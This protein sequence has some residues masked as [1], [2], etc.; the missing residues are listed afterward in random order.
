MSKFAY[1]GR[2]GQGGAVEGVQEGESPAAV[3]RLLSARGV[4]PI[5][6]RPVAEEKRAEGSLGSI[7]LGRGKPSADD[8]MFFCRQMHTLTRSGV[9][10]I[11]GVAGLAESTRNERLAEGLRQV[12]RDL[13]GGYSL[14]HA[15]NQ[16]PDLFSPLIVGILQVGENTGRVDES[17]RQLAFYLERE[18]DTRNRM[19]TA[20]RYPVMV[21]VAIGVAMA[22]INLFV[23]P[24]FAKVF[25]GFNAELPWATR[26]LLTSSRFTVEYWPFVFGGIALVIWG[27]L[28]YIRTETGR[29]WW[30]RHKLRLP[31]VGPI[32]LKSTLGRFARSFAMMLKAGVP[33]VQGLS[34]LTAAV[35]NAYVGG[36]LVDMRRAIERGDSIGHTAAGLGLFPAL[37]LQMIEVGEETGRL[38]EMLVEVAD[39]YD[40][41]V[42]L[43]LKNLGT[44]IEPILLLI[45]G[46]MVLILALG[47]FLPIWDL[48]KV[49]IR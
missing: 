33:L 48:G 20:M 28:R 14:S 11:R 37:V 10:L 36:L 40:A 19:K 39:Y 9:P 1:K 35:D 23:I 5:A 46:V 43:D 7:R 29:L 34:L 45:V 4:T 24:A 25:A 41:E 21:L 30:D 42:D 17:F 3:A 12:I 47:V 44:A 18:R 13:E 6:I 26:V 31:V 22:V 27:W 49:A 38:D 32:L 15:F 2:N 8:L 16:H